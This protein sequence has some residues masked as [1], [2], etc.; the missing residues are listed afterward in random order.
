[1]GLDVT[2]TCVQPIEVWSG[3]VTHNLIQMAEA[4]GLY[5]ALW[6]PDELGL[7]VAADIIPHLV[8]GLAEL[9]AEPDRFRAL[10]PTNRYGDYEHLLCFVN[11]YFTACRN[12]PDATISVS[13]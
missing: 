8:A 13:R 9:E 12:N 2:L 1:M 6:R 3:N 7:V 11:S 10:I 4:A 5:T